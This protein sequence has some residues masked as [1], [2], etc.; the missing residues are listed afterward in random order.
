MPYLIKLFMIAAL[1]A[2][3]GGFDEEI[4]LMESSSAAMNRLSE[5]LEEG[6]RER[7]VDALSEFEEEFK[8]LQP[9][10]KRM[11]HE[12]PEWEKDAPG[13][14]S[15]QMEGLI[16]SYERLMF[17]L[18]IFHNRLKSEKEG[19]EILEKAEASLALMR[20]L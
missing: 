11:I 16:A 14:V 1:V 13:E 8:V 6:G 7:C 17:D 3:C 12:H 20:A 9:R 18:R 5:V 10:L 2:G 4:K 19:G 15:E